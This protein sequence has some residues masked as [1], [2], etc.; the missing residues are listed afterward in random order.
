MTTVKSYCKESA[1]CIFITLIVQYK[2]IELLNMLFIAL[3]T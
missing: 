2:D 3:R 1:A